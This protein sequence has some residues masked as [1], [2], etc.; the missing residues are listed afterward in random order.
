MDRYYHV[1]KEEFQKLW[2][3][4]MHARDIAAHFGVTR[5]FV[6]DARKKFGLEERD[7]VR[8]DSVPDPTPQEIRDRKRELRRRHF[9]MKRA[10]A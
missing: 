9:A 7:S 2:E 8:F 5:S 3:S 10:E 1:N 6:Y 4:K